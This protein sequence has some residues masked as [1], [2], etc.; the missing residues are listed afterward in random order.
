[1]E[2]L[3]EIV[4]VGIVAVVSPFAGE[5][6]CRLAYDELVPCAELVGHVG[7]SDCGH[8]GDQEGSGVGEHDG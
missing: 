2:H 5:A 3:A 1:M 6:L 7:V 4:N 8:T